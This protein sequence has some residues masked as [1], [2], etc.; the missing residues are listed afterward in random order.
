MAFEVEIKFR[1]VDHAA[2]VRTIEAMGGTLVGQVE[3]EDAYLSHPARF[4]PER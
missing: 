2:V 1:A 3:Q 4:R